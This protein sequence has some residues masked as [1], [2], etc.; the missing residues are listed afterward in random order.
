MEEILYRVVS[1]S[2]DHGNLPFFDPQLMELAKCNPVDKQAIASSIT[3]SEEQQRI[4]STDIGRKN[5]VLPKGFI[6]NSMAGNA[7]TLIKLNTFAWERA[8]ATGQVTINQGTVIDNFAWAYNV[9]SLERPNS[10]V[11]IQTVYGSLKQIG[12]SGSLKQIGG[13]G[14]GGFISGVNE[15]GL[16]AAIKAITEPQQFKVEK[17]IELSTILQDKK[18]RDIQFL[19]RIFEELAGRGIL[20]NTS[21][22]TTIKL[23]VLRVFLTSS[24]TFNTFLKWF[25]QQDSQGKLVNICKKFEQDFF[26]PIEVYPNE[27]ATLKEM[28]SGEV[29]QAVLESLLVKRDISPESLYVL[30]QNS[31]WIKKQNLL[32]AIRTGITEVDS[33]I[34]AKMAFSGADI[35]K[36]LER[37]IEK[38]QRSKVS[39]GTSTQRIQANSELPKWL[40]N[41]L[42]EFI[43]D[44]LAERWRDMN[45]S[46]IERAE[47]KDQE[48]SL[49]KAE[50]Y[51]GSLAELLRMLCPN[52]DEYHYFDCI[53]NSQQRLPL[54][55]SAIG[56]ADSTGKKRFN[57]TIGKSISIDNI[58]KKLIGQQISFFFLALISIIIVPLFYLVISII[59]LIVGGLWNLIKYIFNGFIHG[60]R[61][62]VNPNNVSI[63]G[64]GFQIDPIKNSVKEQIKKLLE[65]KYTE[66]NSQSLQNTVLNCIEEIDGILFENE[67]ESEQTCLKFTTGIEELEF[68]LKGN[69]NSQASVEKLEKLKFFRVYFLSTNHDEIDQYLDWFKDSKGDKR[70]NR[71]LDFQVDFKKILG[72]IEKDNQN[73][74]DNKDY[75]RRFVTDVINFI[76]I[77]LI[78]DKENLT[79]YKSIIDW[80][81]HRRSFVTSE[82]LMRYI[83]IDLQQFMKPNKAERDFLFD[84][85]LW[86][87]LKESWNSFND[88][89]EERQTAPKYQKLAKFFD[90][91]SRALNIKKYSKEY[92]HALALYAY[93]S[94]ISQGYV[95]ENILKQFGGEVYGL[96]LSL[97]RVGDPNTISSN[98]KGS[99]AKRNSAKPPNPDPDK[100]HFEWAVIGIIILLFILALVV[101]FRDFLLGVNNQGI[102][103]QPTTS[104]NANRT[105]N[106]SFSSPSPSPE[107][108]PPKSQLKCKPIING[109]DLDLIISNIPTSAKEIHS[110]M[111]VVIGEGENLKRYYPLKQSVKKSELTIKQLD[112]GRYIGFKTKYYIIASAQKP[113]EYRTVEDLNKNLKN[114]EVNQASQDTCY[115]TFT[116]P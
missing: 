77:R 72:N 90:H 22:P 31:R 53:S 50:A 14:S 24:A 5:L 55:Y 112:G 13:S 35:W 81:M 99:R 87:D 59:V 96:K 26:D 38:V 57:L 48:N 71:V 76:L 9:E 79:S 97:E 34:A 32:E 64:G 101:I 116:E 86:D 100:A 107:I 88:Q 45:Q 44:H 103:T 27:C 51:Y 16:K 84:G 39:S 82:D 80:I 109:S 25:N 7:Y 40:E 104:A 110:L 67:N 18:L 89:T 6:E 1:Y 41:I 56:D 106:D 73:N 70:I 21:H 3:L 19:S 102:S 65:V 113:T 52:T 49:I 85:N 111:Y 33:A 47:A 12:G 92:D 46:K 60:F 105:S 28:V 17:V 115:V 10:F 114:F 36:P 15:Q 78:D 62:I 23:F 29:C 75:G 58:E 54:V 8:L 95:L 74:Q 91:L 42:P 30:M 83:I 108:T 2:H 20:P 93:F 94:Q 68:E 61:S 98:T 66:T 37:F 4:F 63:G 43:T 11:V 69:S